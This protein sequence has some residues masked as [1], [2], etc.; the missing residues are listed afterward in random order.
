MI[1]IK[2]IKVGD[3]V[4]GTVDNSPLDGIVVEQR[5]S[6]HSRFKV[7]FDWNQRDYWVGNWEIEGVGDY[8][9]SDKKE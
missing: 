1:D 6:L 7:R 5:D 8:S 9:T 2:S 3:R 4:W